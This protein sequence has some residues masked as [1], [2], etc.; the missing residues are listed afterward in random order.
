MKHSKKFFVG[1]GAVAALVLSPGSVLAAPLPVVSP[2]ACPTAIV[3]DVSAA[4]SPSGTA[5]EATACYGL[6]QGNTPDGSL[7]ITGVG[8]FDYLGKHN[9]GESPVAVSGFGGFEANFGNGT[10]S[11]TGGAASFDGAWAIAVKQARCFGVWTF[12]A[13]TYSGGSFEGNWVS[14]GKDPGCS[15]DDAERTRIS[16][17]SLYG[18]LPTTVSEPGTL[19][20]LGMGLVGFGLARRRR[21]KI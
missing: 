4:E 3:Y 19:A 20:L 18:P 17:L 7:T 11:F 8:T 6:F 1:F 15:L 12:A 14:A 16:H 2:T 5:I 21:T 9:I 10:F 13:G